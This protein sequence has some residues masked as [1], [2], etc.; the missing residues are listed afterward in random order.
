MNGILTVSATEKSS[1]SE[2]EITIKNDRNR[3]SEEEIQ[4]L[5]KEAEEKAEE[6]KKER[7]I[8]NLKNQ[9]QQMIYDTKDKLDSE[10][11]GNILDA[12]SDDDKDRL[13]EACDDAD[14]WLNENDDETTK[15]EIQDKIDEFDSIIRPIVRKYTKKDAKDAAIDDDDDLDYKDEL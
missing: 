8:A 4:R 1:G 12:I 15:Q 9:L 11:D 14:D 3:L 13:E 10:K 5:V 7:D 2:S 6:D